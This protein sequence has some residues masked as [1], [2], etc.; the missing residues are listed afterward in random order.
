LE[1]SHLVWTAAAIV[2]HLTT[3]HAGEAVGTAKCDPRR[4]ACC[5]LHVDGEH[6]V[7]EG[8]EFWEEVGEL[9]VRKANALQ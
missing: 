2:L 5:H 8:R 9:L 4:A 3:E 7:R 1:V 6:G